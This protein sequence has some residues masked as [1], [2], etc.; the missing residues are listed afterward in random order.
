[1]LPDAA[2]DYMLSIF[3]RCQIAITL[4]SPFIADAAATAADAAA[5]SCMPL[6]SLHIAEILMSH[7]PL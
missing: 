4:L 3:I 7:T 2:A 1:L 6:I 5:I